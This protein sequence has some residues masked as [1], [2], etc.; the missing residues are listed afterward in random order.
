MKVLIFQTEDEAKL[1]A[2][3]I[4]LSRVQSVPNSVLGLATGGTMEAIYAHLIEGSSNHSVSWS[5]TVTFNLDEYWGI[6]A[7]SAASYRTY[8]N[9]H[10]FKHI[11]VAMKSTH[12]PASSG[13][14]PS[15]AAQSYEDAILTAGGIDLQLLGI[16]KNGHIGFNE[17]TS[18]LSSRTWIKTLT[19]E[20]RD[21][22]RRFFERL[23]DVPKYALTVGIGTILASEEC[24]IV[25]TGVDKA[26]AIKAMIEGPVSAACP[27]SA[28]QMH[29]N[30]TVLIDN[31]AAQNL[32]PMEYYQHVHP[33]GRETELSNV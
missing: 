3:Q 20:T 15:D 11:D 26:A 27:A 18:S 23:E 22:N 9:E 32:D 12:V 28:L 17:P 13:D 7:D 30:V 4:I 1:R 16:G 10:L 25:G 14:D 21:S 33:E 2:A 24:I 31:D 29:R 6:P 8:M 5:E 19:Q